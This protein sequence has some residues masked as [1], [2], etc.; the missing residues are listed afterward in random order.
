MEYYRNGKKV[1]VSKIS[2]E[3]PKRLA[4]NIFKALAKES[5]AIARNVLEQMNLAGYIDWNNTTKY[6][7]QRSIIE[8]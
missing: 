5:L 2:Y 8:G 7:E 4:E 3:T 6:F 1:D